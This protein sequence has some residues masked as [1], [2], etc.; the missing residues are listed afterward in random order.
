MLSE[1]GNTRVFPFERKFGVLRSLATEN[2][3]HM[4][5]KHKTM[6]TQ[7][8]EPVIN[9]TS[10]MT[11]SQWTN[12]LQWSASTE[13]PWLCMMHETNKNAEYARSKDA[14]SKGSPGRCIYTVIAPSHPH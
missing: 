9:V 1:V 5:N 10:Y 4:Y 6:E 2:V 7:V 3:E 11:P 12:M 13:S 14:M 8:S